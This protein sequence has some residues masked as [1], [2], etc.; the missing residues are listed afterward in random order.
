MTWYDIGGLAAGV[1][2]TLGGF[3]TAYTNYRREAEQKTPH[4]RLSLVFNLLVGLAG[5]GT[6]FTFFG[7]LQ[8]R[9]DLAATELRQKVDQQRESERRELEYVR[10]IQKLDAITD[11]LLAVRRDLERSITLASLNLSSSADIKRVSAN[12]LYNTDTI[13]AIAQIEID[14]L[15]A[16]QFVD[17]VEIRR[18]LTCT[19]ANLRFYGD[20]NSIV[21]EFRSFTAEPHRSRILQLEISPTLILCQLEIPLL[22]DKVAIPAPAYYEMS[23]K[24]ID[25]NIN[26]G[27]PESSFSHRPWRIG[28]CAIQFLN[29]Q[30][31]LYL[32]RKKQFYFDATGAGHLIRKVGDITKELKPT[33]PR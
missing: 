17:S 22:R 26:E 23:N 6:I 12:L 29:R 19:M 31:S 14:P 18:Y 4:H 9:S 1:C 7:T 10:S 5:L 13:Y 32:P 28:N 24:R 11:S 3:G 8:D 16:S 20:N 21:F 15:N 25:F 33:S 2:A 27:G 30:W